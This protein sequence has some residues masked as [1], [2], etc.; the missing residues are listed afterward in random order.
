ME[1]LKALMKSK[2]LQASFVACTAIVLNDVF[3]F[4]VDPL[5]VAEFVAIIIAYVLGQGI[6][7]AGKEALQK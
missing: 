1:L 7:D 6:A 2:K 3:G 4:P 5:T